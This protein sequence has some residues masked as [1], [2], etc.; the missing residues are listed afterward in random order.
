[1][2]DPTIRHG[3]GFLAFSLKRVLYSA[4]YGFSLFSLARFVFGSAVG[5]CLLMRDSRLGDLR[6]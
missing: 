6:G 5:F 3:A 1:M 4:Q 2:D